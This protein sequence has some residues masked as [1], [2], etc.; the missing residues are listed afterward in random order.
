M[1]NVNNSKNLYQIM[2]AS[3][4]KCAKN[5]QDKYN[6]KMK[7]INNKFKNRKSK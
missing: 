3:S 7:K 1:N 4:L 6:N 5:Q 2:K